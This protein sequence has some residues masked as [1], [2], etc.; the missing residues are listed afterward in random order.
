MF[1]PMHTITVCTT[2]RENAPDISHLGSIAISGGK[3]GVVLRTL[4]V[5]SIGRH[6]SERLNNRTL[7][8]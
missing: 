5:Q 4:L 7:L 8:Y 2:C 3:L 1:H 6:R